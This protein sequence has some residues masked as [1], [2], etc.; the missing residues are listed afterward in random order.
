[1]TCRLLL[2]LTSYGFRDSLTPDCLLTKPLSN[3][4]KVQVHSHAEQRL[5]MF[6]AYTVHLTASKLSNSK[7]TS[8][9][10]QEV[11]MRMQPNDYSFDKR[12]A[13]VWSVMTFLYASRTSCSSRTSL[14]CCGGATFANTSC[15]KI[16]GWTEIWFFVQKLDKPVDGMVRCRWPRWNSYCQQM[17][18]VQEVGK[19]RQEGEVPQCCC[20]AVTCI[21]KQVLF[22]Q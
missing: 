9:K 6:S 16:V 20:H 12:L 8:T 11:W 19:Q 2:R 18:L 3:D 7:P 21:C 17:Q 13:M 22:C 15:S 10:G 4:V 14:Y 1:M 5:L